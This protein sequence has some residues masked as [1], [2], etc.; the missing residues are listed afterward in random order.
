MA[1]GSASVTFGLPVCP[2]FINSQEPLEG[3]KQSLAQLGDQSPHE[4]QGLLLDAH[5]NP[6][7]YRG[8]CPIFVSGSQ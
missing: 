1:C 7:D 8:L 3:G 4:F 5:A 6:G 2:S